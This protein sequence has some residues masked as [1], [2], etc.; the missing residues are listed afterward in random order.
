MRL[1]AKLIRN[2]KKQNVDYISVPVYNVTETLKVNYGMALINL[3]DIDE[4]TNIATVIVWDRFVS[5]N[6]YKVSSSPIS[7]ILK[8]VSSHI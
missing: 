3:I 7:H 4:E 1:N 5:Y 6:I 2:Y 8:D